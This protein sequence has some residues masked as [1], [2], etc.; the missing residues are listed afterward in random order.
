MDDLGD[1]VGST[2]YAEIRQVVAARLRRDRARH[3][4]SPSEFAHDVLERGLRHAAFAGL[5]R[6]EIMRRIGQLIR[7]LLVER[8]RARQRVRRHRS[9]HARQLLADPTMVP[10]GAALDVLALHEALESLARLDARHAKI[11]EMRYFGGLSVADVADSLG[12]SVSTV[13]KEER[14]ARAW[15]AVRLADE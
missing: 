11:I 3:T 2:L 4:V 13:E 10:G 8:A 5:P 14:K 9:E 6:S 1:E 15:L 7:H 12:T